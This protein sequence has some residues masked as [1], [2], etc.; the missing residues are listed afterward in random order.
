MPTEAAQRRALWRRVDPGGPGGALRGDGRRHTGPL[1]QWTGRRVC[2]AVLDRVLKGQ[3]FH[4]EQVDRQEWRL[5]KSYCF[6]NF[7]R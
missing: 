7:T 1:R 6:N 4:L 2:R 3:R 5:C